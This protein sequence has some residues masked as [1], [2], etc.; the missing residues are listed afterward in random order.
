M[1]DRDIPTSRMARTAL[2]GKV[3]A[4]Q[5][6]RHAGAKIAMVGRDDD[7]K[8]AV[9][10]RRQA[11]AAQALVDGLGLMRGA[12]MKVGQMLSM[13]DIGLVP[14]EFRADFQ[15]SL[16]QLRDSAP[17]VSFDK[18]RALIEAELGGKLRDLFADFDEKPL[19][20]ASIGQV[21]RARLHDGRAVA[22]KV[23]YPGID[24]AV[25]ADLKNLGM[26]MRAIKMLAPGLDV[27]ATAQE[28]RERIEEEL[29][30]ELEAQNQR[31]AARLYAGHPFIVVPGV[32]SSM[33]TPH[34]LVTEFF[35]GTKFDDLATA[36]QALRDRVAE[37]VFRFFGGSL[38]R[39]HQFSPDPHPGNF[40]VGAD[41]RVAFLDFGLYRVMDERSMRIQTEVLRAIVEHDAPRLHRAFADY[42]FLPDPSRVT[43]ELALRYVLEVFW[44][45]ADDREIQLDANSASEAMVQTVNPTSDYFAIARHQALPA[46]YIFV[47]RM[48]VMVMAAIGQLNA[49][50]NWTAITGEW[51]YGAPPATELGRLD[52]AH[53]GTA[54]EVPA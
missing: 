6:A 42:G 23:Q 7:K 45:M 2:I 21:Y 36:D 10:D 39:H 13:V 49:T 17:T 27:A 40:L 43:P 38:Y 26:I 32:V 15:R 33:C 1:S 30:Y 52:A 48:V 18:M 34:V 28:I 54:I 41:G 22:V 25:R 14:E 19:G 35:E 31:M 44:W 20:A 3:A 16:A 8:R 5:A 47:M 53:F 29:D 51:I 4:G 12:A 50:G 46:E 11:E 37:I 9:L 24:K